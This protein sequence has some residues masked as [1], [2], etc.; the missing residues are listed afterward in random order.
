VNKGYENRAESLAMRDMED[1]LHLHSM[2]FLEF[3]LPKP[4]Y[5]ASHVFDVENKRIQ[6]QY[7]K[8][9]NKEQKAAFD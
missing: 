8:M 2:N 5:K 6:D 7:I 3:N 9:L 1:I 4:S